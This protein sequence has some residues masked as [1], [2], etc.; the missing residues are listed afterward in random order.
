MGFEVCAFSAPSDRIRIHCELPQS[1]IA[2]WGF[3]YFLQEDGAASDRIKIGFARRDPIRRVRTLLTGTS[4]KLSLVALINSPASLERLLHE[5][6]GLHRRTGEWFQS[7]CD[8]GEFTG[9]QYEC[10]KLR[11][12]ILR[13][14]LAKNGRSK[15]FTADEYHGWL[16]RT[17]KLHPAPK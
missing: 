13:T 17:G 16:L 8:W 15:V 9:D 1:G 3:T 4:N 2:G 6:Y 14:A 11:D 5:R 7:E 10:E 12:E